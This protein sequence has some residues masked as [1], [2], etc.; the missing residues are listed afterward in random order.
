MVKGTVIAGKVT[1]NSI[2]IP[3]A[4][5]EAL[6][7][8]QPINWTI[9]FNVNTHGDGSYYMV[10]PAG[11]YFFFFNARGYFG[12]WYNDKQ[13]NQNNAYDTVTVISQ[14]TIWNINADLQKGSLLSGRVTNWGLPVKAQVYVGTQAGNDFNSMSNSTNDNGEYDFTLNPGTYYVWFEYEGSTI[15]YD[16]KSYSNEAISITVTSTEDHS[17]ISADFQIG[18]PPTPPPPEILQVWD[19]PDDQGKNVFV[20]WSYNEPAI[21]MNTE[22]P[23]IV[24]HYSI[25]R[26][27]DPD[28]TWVGRVDAAHLSTYTVSVPTLFDSTKSHGMFESHFIVIAHYIL[29][30][31]T[32]TSLPASG[33]SVDNLA[34]NTPGGV[35]SSIIAGNFVLS[36]NKSLDED[37]RYF[38]VYRSTNKNFSIAGM[39]PIGMTTDPTFSDPVPIPSVVYYYK[40]T[41]TDFSGNESL[42]SN[43]LTTGI[44]EESS[45]PTDFVLHQNFPNP[46]NPSTT[47][48]YE[49]PKESY[50]LLT[51][52][53]MIGQEVRSLINGLKPAGRHT[54]TFDASGLSS[55]M[56]IYQLKA[57][58][59]VFVQKMNLLK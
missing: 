47:I 21:N 22:I 28:T 42:P 14:D 3:N 17:N 8:I 52:Y 34:P 6:D 11:K 27:D 25:W 16:Q 19:V 2:P 48:V 45:L 54:A 23:F 31:A 4:H 50:V 30:I 1:S 56:Y 9:S 51:V 38:S 29:N 18:M 26:L 44:A 13:W 43:S 58:G 40:I 37:F 33:Y 32:L 20:K 15:Y 7:A 24:D 55:G 36:W 49:L 5:V 53:N 12:R 39:N 41:A 57:E 46:F 10:V 59:K 35:S